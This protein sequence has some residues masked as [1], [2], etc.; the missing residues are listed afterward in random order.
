MEKTHYLVSYD[1]ADPKRLQKV[2]K[3]MEDFGQRVLYSVF[4]CLLTPVEFLRLKH[5]V[6][7]LL[8]PLEDRVL[9]YTLCQKCSSRVEHIGKDPHYLAEEELEII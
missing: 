5:T 6:E 8:D 9:Y 7:P 3:I 2:A 4:E 1:I